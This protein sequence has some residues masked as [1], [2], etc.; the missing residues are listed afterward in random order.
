[1]ASAS[2]SR[3]THLAAYV[4][5]EFPAPIMLGEFTDG[6][7]SEPFEL[8]AKAIE[9]AVTDKTSPL[10]LEGSM[11][12]VHESLGGKL[13]SLPLDSLPPEVKTAV[14]AK[15]LRTAERLAYLTVVGI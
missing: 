7:G 5:I 3:V 4:L 8:V 14:A 15:L 6:E 10:S 13:S 2:T 9:G 11:V 12:T 1:M